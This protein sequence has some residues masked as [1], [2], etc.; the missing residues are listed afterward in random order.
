MS[1]CSCSTAFK[2]D[3]LVIATNGHHLCTVVNMHFLIGILFYGAGRTG[4]EY[5]SSTYFLAG[6]KKY[7]HIPFSSTFLVD[8]Q[9][10]LSSVRLLCVPVHL[11]CTGVSL[12][13]QQL[14]MGLCVKLLKQKLIKWFPSL[15]SKKSEHYKDIYLKLVHLYLF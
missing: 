6:L 2:N 4:F 7:K 5:R 13:C 1:L 3:C 14:V 10:S 11:H 12:G 8:L 15:W 9:T